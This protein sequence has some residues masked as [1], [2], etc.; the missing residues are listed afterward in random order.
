MPVSPGEIPGAFR[1]L[2]L[3]DSPDAIICDIS[4]DGSQPHV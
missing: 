1:S 2:Y 4:G 3:H